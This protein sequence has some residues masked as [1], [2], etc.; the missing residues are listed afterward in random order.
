[1][2]RMQTAL[3]HSNAE[4]D[5]ISQDA[6]LRMERRPALQKRVCV[7]DTFSIF[8]VRG[9]LQR[10]SSERHSHFHSDENMSF[11]ANIPDGSVPGRVF[12]F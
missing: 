9:N 10:Q 12:I 7:L 2:C 8:D 1:M 4:S 5:V 11:A 6:R 3:S